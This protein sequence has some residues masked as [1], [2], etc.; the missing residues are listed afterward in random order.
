MNKEVNA[1]KVLGLV[2]GDTLQTAQKNF[3]RL[4]LKYHPDR[5]GGNQQKFQEVVQAWEQIQ[6]QSAVVNNVI[7][8]EP[9][10]QGA[11]AF[12]QQHMTG[13]NVQRRSPEEHQMSLETEFSSEIRAAIEGVGGW[14]FK[15]WG[16]AMEGAGYPDRF[17]AHPKWR[18]WIE[19]KVNRRPLT[20]IQRVTISDMLRRHE[21]AIVVRLWDSGNEHRIDFEYEDGQQRMQLATMPIEGWAVKGTARGI[22]LLE[23]LN[24]AT[25]VLA[26]MLRHRVGDWTPKGRVIEP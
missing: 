13:K 1:L 3:R 18:G 12:M 14:T 17:I 16:N 11:S 23:K 4:S 7:W 25:A 22:H 5:P 8:E 24:E 9:K 19:E 20:D 2:A 10:I 21:P 15:K 6:R 26:Q